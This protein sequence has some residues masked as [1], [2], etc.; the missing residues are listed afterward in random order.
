MTHPELPQENLSTTSS[1]RL[2]RDRFL[3]KTEGIENAQRLQSLLN[4]YKDKRVLVVAPPSAGKSTLLQHIPEGVDMDDIFDTMPSDVKDII[5]Q[6]EGSYSDIATR[7]TFYPKREFVAGDPQKE[8]D[9]ALSSQTLKEYTNAH[10]KIQ[11]GNPIFGT[12]VI[13][14]D[15]IIY[16]KLSDDVYKQRLDSRNKNPERQEQPERVFAI[17]HSIEKDVAEAKEMGVTVE[18]F[19]IT[20]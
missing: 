14:C 4:Q 3:N 18:E 6:R 2:E 7:K 9:L 1:K 17:K 8:E 20:T 19:E 10:M 16:L 5:L 13:D 12:K 15:V 11:P